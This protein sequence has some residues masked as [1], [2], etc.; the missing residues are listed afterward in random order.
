MKK[1]KKKTE[2]KNIV[3]AHAGSWHARGHTEHG[4][5]ALTHI[6]THA[7]RQHARTASTQTPAIHNKIKKKTN[8]TKTKNRN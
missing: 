7:D 6:H 3:R 4:H 1:T 2:I 8:K 5:H